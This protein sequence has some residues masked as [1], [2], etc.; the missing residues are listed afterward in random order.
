[1]KLTDSQ[2]RIYDVLNRTNLTDRDK[3][4]LISQIQEKLVSGENISTINGKDVTK[5]GNIE[6]Q[7]P[8]D[9]VFKGDYNEETNPA[10]TIQD[11]KD[12]ISEVEPYVIDLTSLLAAQ[13]S[14][15][16]S[17]AIGG[18]D[19]L[20]G[21]VEKNK[22]IFGTLAN[23]TVAIGIRILGNQTTL[24]YFVDSV[25][26]LTV[27]EI[28]ITN[29]SSTL[30]KTANTH[31]VL[32]K[33]MIVNSLD[34]DETTLPL[35][36][37][38]GK[39]LKEDAETTYQKITD[40]TLATTDKTIVG[41]I[42]E[43]ATLGNEIK[44]TLGYQGTVTPIDV[45]LAQ[46]DVYRNINGTTSSSVGY[47]IY[48]PLTVKKGQVI[49]GNVNASN[50]TAII[51][52]ID[53]SNNWIRTLVGAET[54]GN[55]DIFFVAPYDMTI[56]ICCAKVTF[57]NLRLATLD[58]FAALQDNGFALGMRQIYKSYGVIYNEETGYYELNGLKDITE[59]QMFEIW[60]VCHGTVNDPDL[61][62]YFA[63]SKIRTT[64]PR[65]KT[66]VGKADTRKYNYMCA[67]AKQLEI[68]QPYTYD[69]IIMDGNSFN[70][71]F[72]ACS[73]LR[74]CNVIFKTVQTVAGSNP[75]ASAF[76]RCSSL[77]FLRINKLNSPLNLKDCPL[78]SYDS[79]K[80]I[81]DNSATT[82][83]VTIYVNSVTYSYLMGT[84]QPTEEVGGTTE[85]WTALVTTAQ[86]K[87]IS[88]VTA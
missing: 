63:G 69:T 57:N 4:I 43:V 80:Y 74:E 22:V 1:M 53:N 61:Q 37:A 31:A 54:S 7:I 19:N 8:K 59:D 35:S 68:F 62:T 20:N 12:E 23:G 36:A 83:E 71:M 9:I 34:S 78:I 24:T 41:A 18:I 65:T 30:T 38:Q 73:A 10:A 52:Q 17:T 49:Y 81:I 21:T 2:K 82:Q 5:G 28:I 45:P 56:E 13:D 84:E 40:N 33:N 79:L 3:A 26:G 46:D 67:Y 11:V 39:A 25:V 87:Q 29:T 48:S 51:S 27:N 75:Y 88:F 44:S 66:T 47:G 15:S 64:L 55:Q 76:E 16:I 58:S 86:E 85:K 42:N 72:K 60:K 70:G 77:S 50:Y 6:I 14:E 32:T